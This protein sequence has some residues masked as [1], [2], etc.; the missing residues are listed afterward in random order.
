[1]SKD[2][3]VMMLTNEKREDMF[4]H[5][6]KKQTINFIV[7]NCKV[8]E[9]TV[10][11]YRELDK[12]D[13]RYAMI[14]GKARKKVDAEL[15]KRKARHIKLGQLLQADAIEAIQKKA[16]RNKS[17]VGIDRYTTAITAIETG[18]KIENEACGDDDSDIE[19]EITIRYVR[20]E[21]KE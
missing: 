3:P 13:K 10:R 21:K 19:E 9:P 20:R 18:I 2:K 16:G 15:V 7:E 4:A 12:W 5:W 6:C 11:R 8:Y 1:M 14:Q 17:K